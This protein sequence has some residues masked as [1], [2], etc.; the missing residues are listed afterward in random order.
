MNNSKILVSGIQPSNKLTLGNYIGAIKNFVKLQNEYDSYLFVADYHMLTSSFDPAVLAVNSLEVIKYYLAAGL[1]PERCRIFYQSAVP[2]HLELCY[3]LLVQTS[4]GELNRMTQFKDKSQQVTLKN[5]TVTIPT[6][7]LIYPVLMAADILMYDAHLVPVG[8]DQRQHLELA[9]NI[10]IRINNK[11]QKDFFVIPEE[12]I[13]KVGARIMDL[14]NP[15]AK[16]SK[17]SITDRGTI[18]LTDPINVARN[19]IMN[20]K[21]DSLNS[22]NFDR[23]NQPGVTNLIEIYC[24]LTDTAINEFVTSLK[25]QSYKVLKEK[26]ADVVCDFLAKIQNKYNTIDDLA[27]ATMLKHN[28]QHCQKIAQKKINQLQQLYGLQHH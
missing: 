27:L 1:N 3:L 14:Q 2:E 6:G 15:L 13:V 5:K 25:D 12:Y 21:T 18:F 4:L 23:E 24:G 11:Y 9:R 7:L 26:V 17:S 20:A 22:I 28:H 8:E 16:M 19:K 10:A